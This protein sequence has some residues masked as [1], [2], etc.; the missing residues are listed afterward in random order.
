MTAT[1]A[2]EAASADAKPLFSQAYSRWVVILLMLVYT[3]NFIDRTIVG[4]LNQPIKVDLKISDAEIGLLNGPAFALLY[5]ILGIPIARLAERYNRVIIISVCL[6]IW[7]LMTALCGAA[8]NFALLLLCRVGVG[9]GE[10]GCSPSAQS[11]ISDYY[12]PDK[13]A[14]AL[15]AYSFGI[16]LGGMLGAISGGLLAQTLG[17][18]LAFVIV[19]LPG[20]LLALIA[21][22]TVKEPPRGYS[23]P[24]TSLAATPPPSLVAV[25]KR[26]WSNPSFRHMTAGVTLVSFAGYGIG[27]FGS[28]YFIRRFGLSYAEVGVI[29]GLIGG[30]S[31][32][33][34]TLLGGWVA[35]R[36]GKSD[37]RWYAWTPAIGVGIAAPFFLS[38]YLVPNWAAA[39]VLAL[40]PGAFAYMYLGPTWGVLH[41]LVEP[42][43]RASA[44]ALLFF[45][46]N[47]IAL[48]GGP[49]FTGLAI[50]IIG[51]RL[52]AAHGFGD[53]LRACPG[54]VA[55]DHALAHA[56]SSTLAEATQLGIIVTM[57]AYVWGALHYVLAARTIRADMAAAATAA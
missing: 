29:F 46:L 10:A 11:L 21:F 54:G 56:C 15:S 38:I 37:W 50:D 33:A 57:I 39:A 23:E 3:S 47:L 32:G 30:F 18:R 17:W 27:A 13:R 42:R 16:P 22:L 9:I 12:A 41:N 14:T 45:V 31:A 49:I 6:T 4:I 53:F 34:G 48:G 36:I 43:A 24:A 7:S 26:M 5:T 1:V 52:F 19:G 55:V 28:P 8:A 2:P 25:A 44:T 40:F 35:D 51:K 20:I